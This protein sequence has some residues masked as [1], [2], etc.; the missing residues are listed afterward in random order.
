[1]TLQKCNRETSENINA[2]LAKIKPTWGEKNFCL[3]NLR[4]RI[5]IL[6]FNWNV[7]ISAEVID[8]VKKYL[9][10]YSILI[11]GKESNGG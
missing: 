11:L 1:L 10:K 7:C 2:I 6:F 4:H 8:S 5:L 9:Q 3:A